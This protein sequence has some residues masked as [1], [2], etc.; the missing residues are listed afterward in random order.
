[1]QDEI[2]AYIIANLLTREKSY[3]IADQVFESFSVTWLIIT[4]IHSSSLTIYTFLF[5]C[6]NVV[7]MLSDN[8]VRCCLYLTTSPIDVLVR[9][10]VFMYCYLIH[11]RILT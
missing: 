7:I 11:S 2:F 5:H 8:V 3:Q 4:H 1:M 9:Y 6:W 10:Y